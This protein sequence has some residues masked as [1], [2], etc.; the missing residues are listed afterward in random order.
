M[1]IGIVNFHPSSNYG[2]TLQYYALQTVLERMG[3]N[4]ELVNRRWGSYIEPRPSLRR[5]LITTITP[6]RA[7]IFESFRKKYLHIS[8]FITSNSDLLEYAKSQDAI[9]AGS[10]QIWNV[11]C[12]DLMG[13]YYLL[14]WV[15]DGVRKLS[16]SASFGSDSYG[17]DQKKIEQTKKLLNRFDSVSVR[18]KS[19][20]ELCNSLFGIKAIQ[21]I[22]PTLLLSIDDYRSLYA[23]CSDCKGDYILSYFLDKTE[24][25]NRLVKQL[26]QQEGIKTID[27]NPQANRLQRFLKSSVCEQPSI[28]QWLRN[29]FDA[30]MVVTDSFHGMVFSLLFN[31]PFIC[32]GNNKRGN[33]RFNSLCETLA[34]EDVIIPEESLSVLLQKKEIKINIINYSAVNK[35]LDIQRERSISYFERF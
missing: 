19:G 35:Q 18:E 22:D 3:H 6:P 14:D 31:K 4:V 9:L 13:G 1:K 12:M 28:Q 2:G 24:E 5:R 15:P 20:V 27:N 25:K 16:Y 11:D 8:R 23:N 21:H 34:L 29:I 17:S 30:R 32:I 7:N 10:D 26:C 33:A